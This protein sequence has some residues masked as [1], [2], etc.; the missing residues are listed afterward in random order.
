MAAI[1]QST[2]ATMCHNHPTLVRR[3]ANRTS[4]R[5]GMVRTVFTSNN[6]VHEIHKSTRCPFLV[7]NCEIVV[8][9]Q[10]KTA[11]SPPPLSYYRR[12]YNNATG[13]RTQ[14]MLSQL[15]QAR[16]RRLV[17]AV[18]VQSRGRTC[19]YLRERV[20]VLCVGVCVQYVCWMELFRGIPYMYTPGTKPP[21]SKARV[22]VTD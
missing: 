10:N 22:F 18:L 21:Q 15:K 1:L 16:G 13:A 5:H 2:T 8:G 12:G 20:L 19:E 3:T 9:N 14:Q 11:P 17:G 7:R 4:V 6:C